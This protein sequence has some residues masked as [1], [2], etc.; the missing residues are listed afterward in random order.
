MRQDLPSIGEVWRRLGG[1]DPIRNRVPALWRKTKDRNVSL[2]DSKG[3]YFD[4]VSGTGGGILD[5]VV[6]AHGCTRSDAYKWLALE[7]NLETKDLTPV[8]RKAHGEA[9][10]IGKI[11]ARDA[12]WWWMA[13]C[14]DLEN[15]KRDIVQAGSEPFE[16][17]QVSNE[18]YR[19]QSLEPVGIVS[20]FAK[21]EAADPEACEEL[22]RA[23]RTWENCC[24][25][26]VK[27]II[28]KIRREQVKA[29]HAA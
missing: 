28:A 2:D 6:Q 14:S 7:F 10:Q 9:R 22:I 5:L 26:A 20:E 23:G 16:L 15:C 25:W 17:A 13:K 8:E 19:L 21:H 1:V 18:L 4:F 29:G 11:L 3:C 24:K 12:L 27:R